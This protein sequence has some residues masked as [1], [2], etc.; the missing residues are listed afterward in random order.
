MR[1]YTIK[2]KLTSADVILFRDLL[3]TALTTE[4]NTYVDNCALDVTTVDT[5]LSPDK[6][7]TSLEVS[8]VF[9]N[10]AYLHTIYIATT[11]S[12]RDNVVSKLNLGKYGDIQST[13]EFYYTTNKFRVE[14]IDNMITV[15]NLKCCN[16][17][18]DTADL[19]EL[20]IESVRD[21]L[22]GSLGVP[23][24]IGD[25]DKDV[26]TEYDVNTIV[27]VY[28]SLYEHG[29]R[30]S[31]SV[32]KLSD[33]VNAYAGDAGVKLEHY[34]NV[35]KNTIPKDGLVLANTVANVGFPVQLNYGVVHSYRPSYTCG[36]PESNEDINKPLM[37]IRENVDNTNNEVKDYTIYI[38]K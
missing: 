14:N 1:T 15:V 29:L 34:S 20:I 27:T 31:I 6:E 18:V 2:N 8:S 26:K 16:K 5:R 17:V 4:L 3:S 32:F 30:R 23:V 37:F 35:I 25:E 22:E 10:K 21:G 12:E 7:W 11:K 13:G 38:L 28:T 33:Y 9:N 19:T 36:H 24:S